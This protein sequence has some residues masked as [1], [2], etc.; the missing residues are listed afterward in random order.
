MEWYYVLGAISYGIFIVQFILSSFGFLE[1]DLDVDFD[2]NVDFSV[3]DLLSFKGLV[4]F[5]MGFSGWLMVIG[6]VTADDC[7]V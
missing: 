6:E 1:T 4:H 2:G 3:S 7:T 5:A